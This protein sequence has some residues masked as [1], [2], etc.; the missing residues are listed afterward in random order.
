MQF[1]KPSEDTGEQKLTMFMTSAAV[2]Q[3]EVQ[4]IILNNE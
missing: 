2:I 1:C 3:K 4:M